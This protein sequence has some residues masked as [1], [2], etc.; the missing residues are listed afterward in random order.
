VHLGAIAIDGVVPLAPADGARLADI[1]KDTG[2][3]A[4]RCLC[5]VRVDSDAE[6]RSAQQL[7]RLVRA[8]YA[9]FVQDTEVRLLGG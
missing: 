5:T 3:R 8:L 2:G 1:V 6:D 4:Q 7:K 9:A